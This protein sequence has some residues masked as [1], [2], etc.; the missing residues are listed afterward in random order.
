MPR[1]SKLPK[2]VSLRERDKK[3]PLKRKIQM[4]HIPNHK[5][6]ENI[7]SL[8]L[9][10]ENISETLKSIKCQDIKGFRSFNSRETNEEIFDEK[11]EEG[12][13]EYIPEVQV[14]KF[15][16][17]EIWLLRNG[18]EF[19]G[20]YLESY[21]PE[22]RG[23]HCVRDIEPYQTI[24]SIPLKCLITDYM[25]RN[26][27]KLGREL[28]Q[29][30]KQREQT[31]HQKVNLST[32]NLIAVVIYI[33][34]TMQDPNHF[35]QPYYK[36]LPSDYSNF[37]IFWTDEKLCWLRGSPILK[38]IE[39]RKETMKRD[40]LEICKIIPTFKDTF[41]FDLFLEV[42]TAVGSRNFGIIV[43]NE[44]RTA[45]VPYADM[46]NHLRPRE[47]SWTFD[48]E[49]Y[50]SFSSRGCFTI[51]SLKR[52]IKGQQVM[53]SYGKKCNSKFFLHY[54][55]AVEKN[56][57]EDGR[58]QNEL[59]MKVSFASSFK[60]LDT[61][62]GRNDL[63]DKKMSYLNSLMNVQVEN[64]IQENKASEYCLSK[65][66]RLT[67][68]VE[69]KSTADALLFLRVKHSTVEEYF[70]VLRNKNT[71]ALSSKYQTFG[72][73]FTSNGVLSLKNELR[74]LKELSQIL[75]KQLSR[76]P[77]TREEN[78]CL[79]NSGKEEVREYSDRRTALIV[80]IGEQEICEFWIRLEEILSKY[81][82]EHKNL[83]DL[84]NQLSQISDTE[85]DIFRYCQYLTSQVN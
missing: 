79:L 32:P 26:C 39:E 14:D 67:M 46:L 2:I 20:L 7:D 28:F 59:S 71:R 82:E 17:F 41:S 51:N 58:C 47:T 56:R 9:D 1:S 68:N 62:A 55:F 52:L 40:Y 57:E 30:I 70:D 22:V 75:K 8:H 15:R 63:N 61:Q 85:K 10:S 16:E 29:K 80:I 84:L 73:S 37:P 35:F 74:A 42:R 49:K 65:V 38:D 72:R 4:P 44:K 64:S 36:I 27:T 13:V 21:A 53:D 24:L 43:N 11:E 12:I 81:V 23:V 60:V 33:L 77:K 45:M 76:Y 5:S 54:G 34:E 3:V 18:A 25:G 31:F 6:E 69:D 48:N 50:S 19:S 83:K 78:L 66:F